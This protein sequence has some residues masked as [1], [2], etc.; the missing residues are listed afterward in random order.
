MKILELNLE[1]GW[2]GGERQTLWTMQRLRDT[3]VDVGL[4]ARTGEVLAQRARAEGFTVHECGNGLRALAM[5]ARVGRQYDLVHAQTAGALTWAVVARP[6]YNRPLVATR[7]VAFPISRATTLL[8]FRLADKVIAISHACAEALIAGG[9]KNI[10][11]ISSAVQ[12]FTPDPERVSAFKREHGLHGKRIVATCAALTMDKDP[13]TLV[14]AIAQLKT[15]NVVLVHFGHGP[16]LEKI[17]A[18]VQEKGLEG[19]YK[20]VGFVQDVEQ[21]YPMM[22]AFVMSSAIE[23][24]GSSVLDA[25]LARVPVAS[26]AAGG[27]RES[28]AEGR[29]RLAPIGNSAALAADID[30]LLDASPAAHA[31]RRVQID[32]AYEWVMANC[33]VPAMGDAYHDL[34]IRMLANLDR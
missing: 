17:A 33:S 2:R 32:K 24:L 19:R 28:C 27:L 10:D 1:R 8:K 6:F 25:M 21:F 4:L 5:L 7:R 18:R 9:V 20:L 34:F 14:D 3:G 22:D 15:P 12:P 31:A 30:A 29:G 11:L 26:T 13:A 16:M 23:G